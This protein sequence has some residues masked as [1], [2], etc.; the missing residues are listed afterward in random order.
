MHRPAPAPDRSGLPLN[1]NAQPFVPGGGGGGGGFA[2][3]PD[4]AVGAW[5]AQANYLGGGAPPGTG[6]RKVVPITNK[7][8]AV[9]NRQ[10]VQSA[11]PPTTPPMQ[12]Q[13]YLNGYGAAAAAPYYTAPPDARVSPNV[14]PRPNGTPGSHPR[15]PMTQ[16][17]PPGMGRT[18]GWKCPSGHD[19]TKTTGSQLV[20]TDSGKLVVCGGVFCRR[21]DKE[22]LDEDVA[23]GY[24]TCPLCN[25]DCCNLCVT[26]LPWNMVGRPAPMEPLPGSVQPPPHLKDELLASIQHL[27]QVV[28]DDEPFGLAG[29]PADKL[30]HYEIHLRRKADALNPPPP[31]GPPKVAVMK[32]AE[33]KAAAKAA[34][35]ASSKRPYAVGDRVMFVGGGR[36]PGNKRWK[37]GATLTMGEVGEV[38][39]IDAREKW[40]LKCQFE[41]VYVMLTETDIDLLPDPKKAKKEAEKEK[42]ITAN[43]RSSSGGGGAVPKKSVASPS[44]EPRERKKSASGTPPTAPVPSPPPAVE[45]VAEPPVAEGPPPASAPAEAAVQQ[46]SVITVPLVIAT[47]TLALGAWFLYRAK[48]RP[49]RSW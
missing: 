12:H 17:T 6:V 29:M 41:R 44:P 48:R 28:G 20:S 15:S 35:D 11:T 36:F 18:V 30:S 3:A 23:K 22:N 33:D 47:A 2:P 10:A 9:V 26:D 31:S 1:A 4:S 16:G 27:L 25:W 13:P 40:P 34:A 5:Q 49:E 46:P 24:F 8:G 19:L 32:D 21:C 45:P 38:M 14:G 43:A 39:E 7:N 37:D 42:R